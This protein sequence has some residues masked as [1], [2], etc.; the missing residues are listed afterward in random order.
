MIAQSLVFVVIPTLLIA[1][2]IWDTA[3]YTIPNLIPALIALA[4]VL[5][6]LSSGL[7]LAAAGWNFAIGLL[8][9]T[10]GFVLFALGFIGGGDAK[11]FAAIALIMGR[12]HALSYMLAAA[13][14]GGGLTIAL[15]WL[16]NMPVPAM[17]TS[18]AWLMRLHD[19]REGVPYGVALAAAAFVLLPYTDL[20][21]VSGG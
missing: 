2:A 9:L 10:I 17:L 20:F 6:A 8:A 12:D 14:F 16:R 4:F 19:P 13:L 15:I 11:L 21:R 18:Q 7:P 1:A 5:C 3:R